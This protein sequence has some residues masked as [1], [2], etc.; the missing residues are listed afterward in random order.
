MIGL[1]ES[2]NFFD[3]A[4]RRLAA[5]AKIGYKIWV[6]HYR[7]TESGGAHAAAA[8]KPL[9]FGQKF[10]CM[11]H[12]AYLH[13]QKSIAIG[14][15]IF[16]LDVIGNLLYRLIIKSQGKHMTKSEAAF[17]ILISLIAAPFVAL[18]S[19]IIS[20]PLIGG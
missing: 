17:V 5:A 1:H 11:G 19:F 15:F 18:F 10:L 16:V 8:N 20:N 6:F 2:V 13:E 3:Q 14:F 9:D 7:L 4:K 12:I